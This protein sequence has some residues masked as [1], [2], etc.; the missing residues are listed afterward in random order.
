MNWIWLTIPITVLFAALT[1]GVPRRT[2]VKSAEDPS[3]G[4]LVV[5]SQAPPDRRRSTRQAA[6]CSTN[7]APHPADRD[8]DL[9]RNEEHI[10]CKDGDQS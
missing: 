1:I 6:R 3:E 2:I 8:G 5:T 4:V 10:P 7:D 9:R